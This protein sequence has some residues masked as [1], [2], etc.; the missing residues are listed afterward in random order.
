MHGITGNRRVWASFK[1]IGQQSVLPVR[2]RWRALPGLQSRR[3]LAPPRMP[4]GFVD[5][6]EITPALILK[7]E[8]RKRSHKSP[9]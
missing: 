9:V 1:D 8:G 6:S 4:E 2:R 3:W 7:S 5:D